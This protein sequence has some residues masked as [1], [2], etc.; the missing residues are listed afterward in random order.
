MA[1]EYVAK[2]LHT[3]EEVRLRGP[4]GTAHLRVRPERPVLAA[5]GGTG[6]APIGSIVADALARGWQ[7]P[8]RLYV[9]AR[10]EIEL[11][12][13]PALTELA[14]RHPQ[15]TVEAVLS[16]ADGAGPYRTGFLHE[17]IAADRPALEGCMV[18][19]AGP[20]P[21]VAAVQDL[22]VQLGAAPRDVHSDPFVPATAEPA[23]TSDG[24]RSEGLLTRLLGSLVRRRGTAAAGS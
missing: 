16:E 17:A 19:A 2:I 5:A 23:R 7:A 14:R 4:F 3:G 13:L 10:S 22:A 9:G 12:A 15:L 6:A 18:Y 11:Y 8:I 20:P 24:V 1:S 21:M